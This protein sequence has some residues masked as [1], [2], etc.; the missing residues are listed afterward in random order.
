MRARLAWSVMAFFAVVIAGYGI[1]YVVIG[2]R[3]YSPD[4]RE[5]FLARPWGINPH[6]LFGAI[7]LI[8][9]AAQFSRAVLQRRR[10]HRAIGIAYVTACFIVGAAGTYMAWYSAGGWLTHVGF[11]LLGLSLLT[12][13]GIA[14]R[15]IRHRDIASHRRWMIR[16]YSLIFAAVTLRLQLPILVAFFGGFRSAYVIV[17]WSSWLPNL[18]FAE[19]RIRATRAT[20]LD[21]L[22]PRM[23]RPRRR[24][25][26]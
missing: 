15:R 18:A 21:A 20:A 16:S 22:R 11:G 2:E 13:T 3:M 8:T 10:L 19:L 6:A 12:T 25:A 23:P 24:F 5:S 7:A 4:L 26:G 17:A 14:F 1:A 9:G